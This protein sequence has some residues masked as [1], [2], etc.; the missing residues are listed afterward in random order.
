MPKCSLL[1]SLPYLKFILIL[2]LDIFLQFW[3]VNRYYFFKFSF[4]PLHSLLSC[5]TLITRLVIF[6]LYHL[7]L[8]LGSQ[9][10]YYGKK[11][12]KS[13]VWEFLCNIFGKIIYCQNF[14]IF[15]H[16]PQ[17]QL[18][19]DSGFLASGYHKQPLYGRSEKKVDENGSFLEP[20]HSSFCFGIHI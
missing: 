12:R 9:Q 5:A 6:S 19:S 3:K 8:L 15:F 18:C 7:Y 13:W 10:T 17:K 16:H 14:S 1:F 4:C 20:Y 11:T 2:Y